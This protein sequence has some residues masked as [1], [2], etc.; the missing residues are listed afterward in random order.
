MSIDQFKTSIQEYRKFYDQ[1]GYLPW[2]AAERLVDMCE[3]LIERLEA[4]HHGNGK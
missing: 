3:S 2:R 1:N 4:I